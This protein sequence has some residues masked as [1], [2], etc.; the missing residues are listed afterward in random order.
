MK[1]L[2]LINL[3]IDIKYNVIL[4]ITNRLTKYIYFLLWKI[5][6]LME[7]IVYKFIYIIIANHGVPNK[8]ISNKNKFFTLK[9]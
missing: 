5:T 8:I 6:I 4:I 3:I 7:N 2:F 9:I 1:L